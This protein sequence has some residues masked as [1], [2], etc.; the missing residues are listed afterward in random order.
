MI[1][2]LQG[3]FTELVEKLQIKD[4]Q[5]DDL[6]SIDSD[7]LKLSSPLHGVIFLFKYGKIDREYAEDNN[8]PIDGTYDENYQ[9]NGIFFANQ[10]IQNACATQAVLNVLLNKPDIELGDEIAN[11]KGFVQGFDGEICGETISNSELIRSVHNSFSSPSLFADEDKQK[12]KQNYDDK[13]DGLFHFIGYLNV[14]NQIYELDGL[15]KYPIMHG[16]CQSNEEFCEKLPEILMRRI[17]K[18]GDELRFSLL[19]ITHDKLRYYKEIGDDLMMHTE[20]M[21]RETWKREN[22]L[23]RHDYVG[24]IVELLKNIGKDLTDEEYQ[25]ILNQAG[26]KGQMRLLQ[27][28]TKNHFSSN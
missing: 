17:S 5:F 6:Y 9:T 25:T 28:F 27:N 18:Y 11:F 26:K 22:E 13:N 4:I 1:L 8:K 15:K 19:T 2:T 23:R 12:P 10:T 14:N 16:E 21:K 20:M 3:V 24:L 7:S